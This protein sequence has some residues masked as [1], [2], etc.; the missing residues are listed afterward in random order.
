MSACFR[1]FISAS[2]IDH[3]TEGDGEISFCGAIEMAG[4]VTINFKVFMLSMA[5]LVAHDCHIDRSDHR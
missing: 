1:F 5:Q 4:I 2:G 3:D